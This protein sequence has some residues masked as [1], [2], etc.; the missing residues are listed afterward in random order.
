MGY[1]PEHTAFAGTLTLSFE[2]VVRTWV[3]LGECVAR[4]GVRKL[5]LFNSHGGQVS[6]M[7][8]VARS[9]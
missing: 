5:V 7:D 4:A 9:H 1:S 8:V 2:T 3:E 6:L